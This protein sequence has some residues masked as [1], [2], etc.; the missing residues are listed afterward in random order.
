M[1]RG[2]FEASAMT[3]LPEMAPRQ[4]LVGIEDLMGHHMLAGTGQWGCNVVAPS[5]PFFSAG[6]GCVVGW[7]QV[8][9]Y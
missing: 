5:Q 3:F 8:F 1:I 7:T 9:S 6:G 4:A 2:D